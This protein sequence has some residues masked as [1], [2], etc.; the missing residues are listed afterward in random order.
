LQ[1]EISNSRTRGA[2]V[3]THGTNLP[4]VLVYFMGYDMVF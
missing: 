2:N 3:S 1:Y 4:L